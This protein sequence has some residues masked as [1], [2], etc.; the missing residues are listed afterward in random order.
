MSVEELFASLR[1]RGADVT[2]R[3]GEL[4]VKGSLTP[5]EHEFAKA[6]VEAIVAL[7]QPPT[8]PTTE[9]AEVRIQRDLGRLVQLQSLHEDARRAAKEAPLPAVRVVRF[10]L[11]ERY[12]HLEQLTARDVESLRRTGHITD[13]EVSRWLAIQEK[14]TTKPRAG[15]IF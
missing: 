14:Q 2:V 4:V 11:G 10:R 8:P 13:E 9:P 5:E 12:L 15:S 6:N 3:G 7:L 1:G